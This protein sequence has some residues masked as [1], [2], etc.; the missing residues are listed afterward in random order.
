MLI[1]PSSLIPTETRLARNAKRLFAVCEETTDT[2]HTLQ[3]NTARAAR[4]AHI[5]TASPVH[6]SGLPV[7]LIHVVEPLQCKD[8]SATTPGS[9]P[10]PSVHLLTQSTRRKEPVCLYFTH[11][12]QQQVSPWAFLGK[13]SWL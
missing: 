9:A 7:S 11:L 1:M 8:R 4:A 3:K 12:Q 6:D 13:V 2:A 5:T 10:L